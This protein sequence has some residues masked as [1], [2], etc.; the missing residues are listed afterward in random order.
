M[1]TPE[2]RMTPTLHSFIDFA[3]AALAPTKSETAL[4]SRS[5]SAL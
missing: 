4:A 5:L 1:S 3:Q 2:R